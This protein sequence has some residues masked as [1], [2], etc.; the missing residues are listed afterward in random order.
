MGLET[1][2]IGTTVA[3]AAAGGGAALAAT[4][5]AAGAGIT[6]AQ[7]AASAFATGGGLAAA[8]GGGAAGGGGLFGLIGGLSTLEL[9]EGGLT[10]ASGL[11]SISAGRTEQKRAEFQSKFAVLGAQREV[12]EGRRAALVAL[13]EANRIEGQQ[14]ASIA[15]SGITT[16]GTPQV[17]LE[18]TARTA[19]TSVEL[20]RLGGFAAAAA[21]NVEAGNILGQGRAA[22]TKGFVGAFGAGQNFATNLIRRR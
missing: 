18:R 11:A 10:A 13:E 2:V 4:G 7:A 3:P 8:A 16:E 21:R 1:A 20:A 22:R 19:A 12:L 17:T 5:A 15:S 6:S 9:V 14:I